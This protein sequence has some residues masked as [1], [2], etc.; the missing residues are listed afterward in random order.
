MDR[1]ET[2][3]E[4]LFLQTGDNLRNLLLRIAALEWRPD[5]TGLTFALLVHTRETA[6]QATGDAR[7]TSEALQSEF[8]HLVNDAEHQVPVSAGRSPIEPLCSVEAG[9]FHLEFLVESAAQPMAQPRGPKG[10]VGVGPPG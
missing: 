6:G 5:R 7:A 2:D 3:D 10:I 9:G 1:A 4:E 8:W